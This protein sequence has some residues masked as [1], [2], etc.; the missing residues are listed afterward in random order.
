MSYWTRQTTANPD[1]LWNIPEQKT[2]S[3]AIIGGSSTSFATEVK[4]TELLNRLNLKAV[5]LVLPVSLKNQLPPIPNVV[6][7]PANNSGAF[8][9]SSELIS[10]TSSVDAALIAGDLSKN[11]ATAIAI[12]EAIRESS[13]P[14]I[15]TRDS[16]DLVA[17]EMAQLLEQPNLIITATFAQL[18]KIFRSVYYPKMLLLSM[19]LVQAVETLHKFTLSY[20]CTILTFHEEQIIIARDGKITTIPIKTTSYSPISLFSGEL[21]AKITALSAWNPNQLFTNVTTAIH[22]DEITF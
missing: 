14:I 13:C 19:P 1:L 21:A 8:K 12:A 3:V 16:I 7:A 6:F 9:K 18:Q 10:A 22:W 17:P 11:S 4:L 5:R 15:L 2:G 20:P